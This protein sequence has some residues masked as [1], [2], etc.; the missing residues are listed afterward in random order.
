MFL[1]M[2]P[3]VI[4]FFFPFT[5]NILSLNQL[6]QITFK[7]FFVC[8]CVLQTKESWDAA[9]IISGVACMVV[10]KLEA[11]LIQAFFVFPVFW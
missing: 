4:Y 11:A 8:V 7:G 6:Y 5:Y 1:Y 2:L 9:H 3:K 10:I